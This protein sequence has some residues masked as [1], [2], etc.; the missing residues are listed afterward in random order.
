MLSS[1][2]SG[3]AKSFTSKIPIAGVCLALVLLITLGFVQTSIA[4]NMIHVSTPSPG[5]TG[6]CSLQEAIYSAEFG[7][8]IALNQADPDTPYATACEPGTGDGDTIIL[9]SGTTYNFSKSWDGDAHNYMGRTAT[10]IIF[11]NLTISGNG[12]TLAWTDNGGHPEN[13][14]L[15]AVGTLPNT[16]PLAISING[17]TYSGTGSLTLSNVYVKNFIM[18][19]GNG[20]AGSGGGLGAG[21]AVYVDE[22]ASLTLENST[23]QF[24]GAVGGNGGACATVNGGGGGG[25]SGNG[26]FGGFF[27]GGG[28]GGAKGTGGHPGSSNGGGGGGGTVLDGGNGVFNNNTGTDTGGPGG[29]YCGANGGDGGNDGHDG[30]RGGGGGGGGYSTT[31]GVSSS[32]NGGKGGYGGGGG[33]GAG[34][35]GD[36]GFGGGGGAGGNGL[37]TLRGGNGGYGGG[38]AG[39]GNPGAAST[40]AGKGG[41]FGGNALGSTF[42]GGGGGLGGAIFNGGGIV[43][44]QNSTFY[45]NYA[46]RG[47]GGSQDSTAGA[48]FT[49]GDAGFFGAA[50]NGGDSGGAIFSFGGSLSVSNST[51][52]SN[53]STGAGGGIVFD[54]RSFCGG[55]GSA[56]LGSNNSLT[57]DNDIIAKNG[58]EECIVLGSN[59]QLNT[60]TPAGAANLIMQNDSTRPCPGFA[61][62]SDPQLQPLQ[63]NSPGNTPTM[64]IL[65]SSPAANVADTS[66]SLGTDQRGVTRPQNGGYDIGAYEARSP[67]FSFSTVTSIAA[68]VGGSGSTTITV[69]SF[70]YFNSAV[71]LT[72]QDEP[73]GV[74]VTLSTDPVTPDFNGSASS[75]LN[76]TLP[77]S[78]PAGSYGLLIN[79][80]S[81]SPSL[82]HSTGT[83]IVVTPT[84]GGMKNVINSF[85]TTGAIDRSGIAN[86]LT[87]KLSVAQTFISGGDN[88]TA[89]NV[90]QALLNQLNAQ[91]GKHISAAAASALITDTQALQASLGANLRP[92]PLVGYVMNSSTGVSGAVVNVFSPSNALVATAVTDS[93]GFYFFPL[94]RA[95]SLGSGYTVKVTL[96][97]GYKK[98]MPA[99]QTFSWQ[100]SQITFSNFVVN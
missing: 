82:N 95:F 92:N 77:A 11:K 47:V 55:F 62:D 43:T 31:L 86:A 12:A 40:S 54:N 76:V 49:C 99:S 96:P 14:R 46:T 38:G 53:Q 17:S 42:G 34:D 16:A 28:G 50:D 72:V 91:S 64:A 59:D 44:I 4:G 94:T 70:E 25:L 22:G 74:A 24:N 78:L 88:Q 6:Q 57:L 97:K 26:G 1:Q 52:A 41:P 48:G 8:S 61:T 56:C 85:L 100:G 58:A 67:D 19:G 73:A 89:T 15:F 87:S 2:V 90:L 32:G 7:E 65:T 9:E 5:V 33:G 13:F 84:T 93:T 79:G 98:S 3:R 36:G 23:F 18:H 29:L 83:N 68:D 80:V 39:Y 71:T 66:T 37:F 60:F 21:G 30:C 69:D 35:G 10:P 81:S 27:A 51:I 45:D 20:V 75:T 63:P